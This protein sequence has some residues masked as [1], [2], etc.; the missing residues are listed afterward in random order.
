MW[1]V[2][3]LLVCEQDIGVFFKSFLCQMG[4][5]KLH[6]VTFTRCPSSFV[7]ELET[8]GSNG[9]ILPQVRPISW[10]G[11]GS[12]LQKWPFWYLLTVVAHSAWM[13]Y[14]DRSDL[15]VIQFIHVKLWTVLSHLILAHGC[16]IEG[17]LSLMRPMDR[18]GVCLI[19][20]TV[21]T[22]LHY[23]LGQNVFPCILASSF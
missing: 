7:S 2:F 13:Q 15:F 4:V 17:L 9:L 1:E 23:N 16:P 3:P 12:H 20:L 18:K 6:S 8:M 14:F 21:L 22:V 5:A 10:I 11:L 19:F